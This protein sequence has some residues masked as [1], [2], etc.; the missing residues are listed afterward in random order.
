MLH[1]LVY[2]FGVSLHFHFHISFSFFW[3]VE[4]RM[5]CHQLMVAG[6]FDVNKCIKT[7]DNKQF[8]SLEPKIINN[9]LSNALKPNF[10]VNKCVRA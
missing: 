2:S 8:F 7:K 10:D 1:L 4:I 6:N 3:F 9:T 5:W